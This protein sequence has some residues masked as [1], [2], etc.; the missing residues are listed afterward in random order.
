MTFPF[1][2]DDKQRGT[3]RESKKERK[4]KRKEKK[5]E[6]TDGPC[7]FWELKR[8]ALRTHSQSLGDPWDG[9]GR[10]DRG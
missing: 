1:L 8:R 9:G 10:S 7:L 5:K 3:M 2:R 6:R 4:G